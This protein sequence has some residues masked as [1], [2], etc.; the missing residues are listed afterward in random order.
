MFNIKVMEKQKLEIRSPYG[1]AVATHA[2]ML[3]RGEQ[4]VPGLPPLEDTSINPF[5][6]SL[7]EQ[8]RV[9]AFIDTAK[10]L[11]AK[12]ID[13][14]RAT[15]T[16]VAEI[17][18]AARADISKSEHKVKAIASLLGI[19]AVQAVGVTRAPS[20]LALPAAIKVQ[21]VTGIPVVAG[22][23]AAG[24]IYG[25]WSY[26][27]ARIVN[28]GINHL[29]R[30]TEIANRHVPGTDNLSKVLPG[31]EP[32]D[33]QRAL[34]RGGRGYAAYSTGISLYLLAAGLQNQ[35]ESERRTLC[36]N[37]GRDAGVF[38]GSLAMAA[39][40]AV[41]IIQQSNPKLGERI[42][43]SAGDSGLLFKVM[44]GAQVVKFAGGWSLKQIKKCMPMHRI[45]LSPEPIG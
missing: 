35:S 1:A 22:G 18:R 19:L 8:G 42:L 34:T 3:A 16:G 30:T 9:S 10:Q 29:P 23:A 31:L 14:G 39:T 45:K 36:K 20:L 11:P 40:G 6:V 5:A 17:S 7:Q 43:D 44:I 4:A 33:K 28:N 15:K 13:F 25:A 41:L 12:V 38:L 26:G 24:S 2:A 21:K 32:S 37:L 27:V